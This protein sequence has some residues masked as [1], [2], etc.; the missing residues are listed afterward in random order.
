MKRST[1]LLRRILLIVTLFS[2]ASCDLVGSLRQGKA[3]PS[4]EVTPPVI[5]PTAISYPSLPAPKLIDRT[6]AAY[7]PQALDEP[8]ELIF[9]QPMDQ[10]SVSRAFDIHPRIGGE[11]TWA[12]TRTLR[13]TPAGTFDRGT[14]YRVT[15]DEAARNEE[16]KALVEP[17]AFEFTTVG[18]VEIA[19]VQPAPDSEAIDPDTVITVIFSRPIVPL[20]SIDR[21]DELPPL[22]TLEPSVAGKGEWINTTIYRFYPDRG[23]VP[24]TSYT[25]RIAAGLV[26]SQGAVLEE[27]YE[28]TFSTVGPMPVAWS[29]ES[30]EQH[31]GVGDVISITFNQPMDR[32]SVEAAFA[33]R[34]NETPVPVNGTF[35][36][37][38]GTGPLDEETL[39][40]TPSE[41]FPRIAYVEASVRSGATARDNPNA[42]VDPW[43][44]S[45]WT[46]WEPAILTTTPQSGERGVDVMTNVEFQFAGPMQA[47][48]FLDHVSIIPKPTAVYTYWYE[49]NTGVSLSFP[50]SPATTYRVTVDANAPDRDGTPL[51]KSLS[52]TFTTSD[53]S[54]Y[55]VFNA[56]NIIGTFDA[57]TDTVVY[58]RHRNVTRLNLALYRLSLDTFMRL[59]GYDSWDY[60][61]DFRPAERD[62]VRQ[63][64]IYP[65][66]PRNTSAQQ[67]IDLVDAQ[68]TQLAPGI[69]ILEL[70]TPEV[71]ARS[72]DA[73]PET[74]TFVRS[75][76]NLVL[77]QAQSEALVWATDL[78]TGKPVAHLPI[79]LYR[80]SEIERSSGS[81]NRDGL[82]LATDLANINRWEDAF[83]V[84]GEPGDATFAI[85]YN[86]WD[87][88]IQHWDFDLNFQYSTH[89]MVDYLYTDRPIYRPGQTVHFKGI[90]RRDNDADYAIPTDIRTLEVSVIDSQGRE[91]YREAL[92]VS[93]MG[94]FA[95]ELLLGEE[96]PLGAYFLQLQDEAFEFYNGA[97]FRVAEYRKPDFEITVET[98]DVDT[99]D[100]DTIDVSVA[101]SY[102]FGGPVANADLT[103]NVLSA[104]FDFTYRCPEGTVCPAYSWS[105]YDASK[106]YGEFYGS[107]GRLVASGTTATD[108]QGNATFRVSADIAEEISSRSFTIEANITD[109][110]GQEVSQRTSATIHRGAFYIGLATEQT[111]AEAGTPQRVEI[112]TADWNSQPA[113]GVAVEVVMMERQWLS[114]RE[115][116]ESGYAYWT[117]TAEDTPVY[118]TTVV[119]DRNGKAEASFVPEKSG[120]YRVRASARDAGPNRT[121]NEIRSSTYLWVW[122][123]GEAFWRRESTNRIELVADRDL[124]RVGDV[125]EILIP[126]PY[127]GTVRALITQERGHILKAEVRE[128]QGT[129]EV[130]HVPI[131]EECVPNVYV[132][133]IL[134]QGSGQTPERLATFKMGEVMLAVS[135]ETKALQITLTPDRD[136]SAGETY[137][138]RETAVY[139]VRVTDNTGQP[140]KAELSLRLVDL[141]VLALAE[142]VGPTLMERF[143]SQ[144]GIGV[145]TSTPLAVAMEIYNRE[146]TPGIKGGGGGCC[147][148][149]PGFV[150]TRFADT[151]FWAAVV[152]TGADGHTR[153]EVELPDNLTTW[154][155]QAHAVTA[156]TRVGH[157]DVDIRT[158]LDLSVRPVLPRFF[159]TGDRAEIATIVQNATAEAIEASVSIAV[160]GLSID[161]MTEQSVN[162][163]ASAEVRIPWMVTALAGNQVKVQ[164]EARAGTLFDGK[165]DVLPLYAFATPE[166]VATAGRISAPGLLQEVVQLPH[167]FDPTQG[168]LT[169]QIDGSL[170]AAAQ[171]ALDYLEHYPYE[172]VEQTVSRFLPN[173]L[174]YQALAEMGL[175]RPELERE[176]STQ[177]RVAMQRLYNEQHYD[178]GWGWW[179]S[180]A[181]DAYLTAYVLQ[182][183][184]EAYRAGFTVD[185]DVI[186]RA[187]AHLREGLPTITQ[188]SP[189]WEANRLAY[190]LYVLG[191][192]V[193]LV[194]GAKGE[195]ELSRATTLFRQRDRLSTYGKALLV[196]ALGLLEPQEDIRVSILLADLA[197]DAVHS[198]TGTHWE[199]AEPDYRNMNTDVRTSAM[200]LWAMARHM[201]DSEMLPGAVRW[202]MDM[203]QESYW[204]STHTTSWALMA[205][206]ATMRAT[207]ELQGDYSYTVALNGKLLLEGAVNA[208]TIGNT[209]QTQVKIADLLVDQANRLIIERHPP[210]RGQSGEGQLYYTAALRTFVPVEAVRALDRGIVVARQYSLTDA[211]DLL[212]SEAAVG[213]TIRVKVTVIAPT[214]L[215]YVTV[216]DPLPAGCEAVDVTLNTT[217]VVGEAPMVENLTLQEKDAWYRWYGWGWWWFS[218]SE[219][220]DERVTLFSTY[221]PRGTYEYTY[222]IRA[223]VP[224][225][226]HVMPTTAYEMYYPEV[227]G[228]SDGGEFV[229]LGE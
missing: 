179:I 198:A 143:W 25:A 174:T 128:L 35:R 211:P 90:I 109:I 28:W 94:T 83:A 225:T 223:S 141:S 43:S 106:D 100:G 162:I 95:D 29:P 85:A 68:G 142:D 144:R 46:V 168:E 202:L 189:Q 38:G 136:L 175:T 50:K 186:D 9:D 45:F 125:A 140:V 115:E 33:L 201:P 99:L 62:L 169:V 1:R 111:V 163:P 117:W 197:G 165:E 187:A 194:P 84:A 226:Y 150:R 183:M 216:E 49:L 104:P 24:S 77:K 26:D 196:T 171:G 214:D 227:F 139:D 137:H 56:P 79:S 12:D 86:G 96:A 148:D 123:G 184:L 208:E 17:V 92:P 192:Y 110:N 73:K 32:A 54:P 60:R 10:Q 157:A 71:M 78:A 130:L 4:P 108:A 209:Q 22:L 219:M 167:N 64:S 14:V 213:D 182:G 27:P 177:V 98:D 113:P 112:L 2:T 52:L 221:L 172:C 207:G 160:Q 204:E 70:S 57:Y 16:G 120:T 48:A 74:F 224:G 212:V 222:V 53:L 181:S 89:P 155:M 218:N 82:Y 159:V 121:G 228:R 220:R 41:P 205:L 129:A 36:W 7:E 15:V 93:N 51:G 200:V 102:Y 37:L 11:L 132:S 19:E 180:D 170:M 161:S 190:E 127:S 116:S 185:T 63:W 18:F 188:N 13:F 55:A 97:S 59:H 153:V 107:Y 152:T 154:R 67:R 6:P 80:A 42:V 206:I 124:Y 5:E 215:Y 118:T 76:I 88:G 193:S 44:W 151:A 178:G 119:T 8:L 61:T 158:A 166:T 176:L 131:T 126:S 91:V 66:A 134:M 31:V 145:R 210:A 146:L 133:V 149:I 20:T 58:A 101:A 114:V 34:V 39:L 72:S 105:D 21:Q 81:T 47:E 40:F 229:V 195:G 65:N 147:D 103:W 203:R 199:E 173:V 217:S 69:Y 75:A 191:E 3:T 87:N 23:L 122:G 30:N 138:P 164:M 156:D 135:T